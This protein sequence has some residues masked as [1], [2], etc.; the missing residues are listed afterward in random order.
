MTAIEPILKNK[1]AIITGAGRG[2]GKATAK[3]FAQAG[4]LV[5]LAAR[6]SAEITTTAN[7][8]KADGGHA[9][10]IPTDVTDQASIDQLIIL[11]MRAFRQVDILVNNAAVIKPMGRVWEVDPAEW[12][13]LIQTNVV[14]PYLCA[15]AILPHM[16]ERG[17]GHIINI[18]SAAAYSDIE[19]WSAYCASKA[20]LDRFTTILAKEVS[21]TNIVVCGMSPGATDTPMQADVRNANKSALPSVEHFQQK[22]ASGA[23]NSPKDAAKLNLWLASRDDQNGVIA[24]LSDKLIR[25]QMARDLP[26]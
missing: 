12:Q 8:I 15:R 14:G 1:V 5:V 7:E 6:T 24:P 23:L 13:S 11:T 26:F 10:A 21:H 19:G 17:D 4:A 2:I 20:A 18:T 9:L 25:E 3:L 22:H 16:L